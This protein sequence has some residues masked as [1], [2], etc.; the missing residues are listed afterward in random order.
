MHAL[1]TKRTMI[2]YISS[3]YV[4]HILIDETHPAIKFSIEKERWIWVDSYLMA[5]G[6]KQLTRLCEYL[7][8][9]YGLGNIRN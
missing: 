7:E 8:V 9:F 4:P 1:K 2:K 5:L 3:F 6:I